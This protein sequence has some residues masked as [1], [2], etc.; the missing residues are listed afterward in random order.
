MK[1]DNFVWWIVG[2]IAAYALYRYYKNK[3]VVKVNASINLVEEVLDEE[4][5]KYPEPFLAQYNVV[6]PADMVSK[7]VKAKGEELRSG[8]YAIQAQRINEPVYI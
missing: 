3:N 8:R 2:G 1:K 6:L 7:R 4:E 5:I